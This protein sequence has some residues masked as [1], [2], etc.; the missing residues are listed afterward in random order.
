MIMRIVLYPF[1]ILYDFVTSLRNRL[2]DL[3]YKPSASFDLP[4]I[5][6]GNL[7][8]GGTGKTP[9]VEYLIR[10]LS[11]RYK[12]ATLSRGYKRTTRGFKIATSADNASTLGDEPYQ[13]FRKFKDRVTVAVGEERALA[14]PAILQEQP[15]NVIL[16]DDAF[17]HRRVSPSFSI[18]LT[19]F[20]RPFDQDVLLPAGRLRE[21]RINAKRADVI[22][23]TKCPP[24][25]SPEVMMDLEKSIRKYSSK[26]VF[27]GTVHY[28]SPVSFGLSTHPITDDVILVTGIANAQP[29]AAFVRNNFRVV[30]HFEFADHHEYT[31]NDIRMVLDK[32]KQNPS[33]SLLTTEKDMVKLGAPA[34]LQILS[35]CQLFFLPISIQFLKSGQDFDEM[36]LTHITEFSEKKL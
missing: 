4:V 23:V 3:G 33:A 20:N 13:F 14:I 32:L 29:L 17:Q 35:A 15:V 28:G 36:L 24:T 6:I 1:A 27:F 8:V 16:L 11:D 19:D 31:E 21:S 5:C 10:L 30:H 9:M 25:L 26:P 7:S 12:I 34:F 22:V 2:Y 18:L